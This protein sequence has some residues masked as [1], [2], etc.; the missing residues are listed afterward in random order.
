MTEW[1]DQTLHAT[2]F[3]FAMLAAAFLLGVF[4]A[5]V[6]CCNVGVVGAIAGYAGSS[7]SRKMRDTL[8]MAVSFM[9]GSVLSL[10]VLG[11]VIGFAGQVIGQSF[12]SYSKI[13]AGFVLICFGLLTLNILP[14]KLPKFNPIYKGDSSGICGVILFGF[15]LGGASVVCCLSCCNPTLLIVLGGAGMQGQWLKSSL[16]MGIFALGYS[17]PLA[18]VVLGLSLGKWRLRA[19]KVVPFVRIAGGVLLLAVGFYFLQLGKL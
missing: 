16:L 4:T 6:S 15:A 17:L 10:L 8:I 13:F 3:N 5:F 1:I 9:V 14:F 2:G 19:G 7:E 18:G 12:G 11:A